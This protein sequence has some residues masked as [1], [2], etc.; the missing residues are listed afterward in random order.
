V[1]SLLAIQIDVEVQYIGE[2][3]FVRAVVVSEMLRGI[4]I[5]G[6]AVEL[7]TAPDFDFNAASDKAT[8]RAYEQ[9]RQIAEGIEKQYVA[10]KTKQARAN[11]G[12]SRNAMYRKSE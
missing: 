1:N 2:H 12:T 10:I 6:C 8:A 11:T 4:P 5:T 9:A 7:V 3:Y